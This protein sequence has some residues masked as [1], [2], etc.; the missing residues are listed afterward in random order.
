MFMQYEKSIDKLI[1]S[2]I[3]SRH[4]QQEDLFLYR[5]RQSFLCFLHS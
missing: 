3:A 5:H 1:Q 2:F 4:R